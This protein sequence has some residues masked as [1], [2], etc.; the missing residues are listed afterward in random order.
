MNSKNNLVFEIGEG[1]AGKR[2]D[3]VVAE[4]SGLSRAYV[5]KLMGQGNVTVNGK[6][7]AKSYKVVAGDHIS[8]DIP[9]P[10]PMELIPEKMPLRILFEDD[11]LIVLSKPPGLVAHPGPGHPTGTLVHGLLAHADNLSGIGGI[12][13]PGIIHRLDKDTSGLMI[14]AKTDFA[15][16]KLSEALKEREIKKTYW[17]LVYG[18]FKEDEGEIDE[19]VGRKP[20]NR[21]KMAVVPGGRDAITTFHVRERFKGLTLVEAHPLTGRTHQIRVHLSY[22]HHPVAGDSVYGSDKKRDEQLGI[23]RQLLHAIGLSFVHPRTGEELTFKDELPA[24]F[25]IVLERLRA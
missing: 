14:V 16:R 6:A 3:S 13:R 25:E 12:E 21:Q 11:D 15:H 23:G 1:Q 24:D 10:E 18:S 5:V 2:L 7:P 19:P 4:A 8:V 9:P 20:N 22:I 17:A